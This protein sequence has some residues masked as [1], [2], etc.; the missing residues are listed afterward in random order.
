[1]TKVC[2]F[3]GQGAQQVGMGEALFARYPEAEAEASEIL[4]WSL[5]RLCLEDPDRQLGQTQFTQPAIY[6]VNALSYRQYLDDGGAVPEYA[7]GHSLGEY[8]ALQAAGAFDFATGLRL[9]HARGEMMSRVAGGG[10]LAVIGL[11]PWQVREVLA[12]S[13]LDA[14]EIANFNS[15][16]QVVLAGPREALDLAAAAFQD[17]GARHTLA[18]R[19]SAA[20]HSS[21]MTETARAFAGVLAGASFQ[22]LRLSVIANATALP[23]DDDPRALLARQIDHPVRWIESIEYLLRRGAQAFEE[24]GV[25]PVLTP[26]IRNIRERSAFADGGEAA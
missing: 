8:N 4:G 18:L 6:C 17:A 7:A 19:V 9:V 11:H 16:E 21:A 20:F 25:G 24:I 5:R 26:M 1:M 3:P 14:V 10:M 22:P 15:Y 23:Y 2:I 12:Q 13:G